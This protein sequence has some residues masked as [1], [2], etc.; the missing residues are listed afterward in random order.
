M[1]F[2]AV[3]GG[4]IFR[5]L[6]SAMFLPYA[7]GNTDSYTSYKKRKN[8]YLRNCMTNEKANISC[9]TESYGKAVPHFPGLLV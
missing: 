7:V 8:T 3:W 1:G 2:K 6:K 4:V 9:F 5:L